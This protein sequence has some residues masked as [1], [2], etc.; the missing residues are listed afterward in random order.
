VVVAVDHVQ[1]PYASLP[2]C[3]MNGLGIHKIVSCDSPLFGVV[4]SGAVHLVF[5][6]VG[7]CAGCTVCGSY[8]G[9]WWCHIKSGRQLWVV[10]LVVSG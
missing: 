7:L 6:V 10:G 1:V 8:F 3:S 9:G 5:L 4:D 2:V